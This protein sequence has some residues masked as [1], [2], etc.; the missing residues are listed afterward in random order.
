MATDFR[1]VTS[2][3]GG[4]TARWRPFVAHCGPD[5][6]ANSTPFDWAMR[7]HRDVRWMWSFN[8]ATRCCPA[9]SMPGPSASVPRRALRLRASSRD[10][11][12][13]GRTWASI[14][15]TRRRRLLTRSRT[16][17]NARRTASRYAARSRIGGRQT[18]AVASPT[19]TSDTTPRAMP[20]PVPRASVWSR[21]TEGGPTSPG[22]GHW[23]VS[24]VNCGLT[25]RHPAGAIH[26]GEVPT[27]RPPMGTIPSAAPVRTRMH[28]FLAARVSAQSRNVPF[29]AEGRLRKWA[30]EWD[31]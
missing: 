8:S 25:I 22:K 20:K 12:G 28:S 21:D 7:R 26:Q 16:S 30:R 27:D 18:T 11:R 3:A 19:R 15:S 23:A 1:S 2:R 13:L 10:G 24:Y 6:Y 31:G 17:S 9:E 29:L 4:A 5:G 14:R